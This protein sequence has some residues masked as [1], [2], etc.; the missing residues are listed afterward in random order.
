MSKILQVTILVPYRYN[1]LVHI[2]IRILTQTSRRIDSSSLCIEIQSQH[3][4]GN[5]QG[6]L[7]KVINNTYINRGGATSLNAAIQTERI[8]Y[9]A[10]KL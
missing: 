8:H 4:F 6:T 5:Y 3:A 7:M 9:R 10:G 1:I 2:K